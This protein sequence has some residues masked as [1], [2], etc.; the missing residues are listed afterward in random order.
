MSLRVPHANGAADDDDTMKIPR[1]VV[2]PRALGDR[3]LHGGS[4]RLIRRGL[5][6]AGSGG[7]L[8][9]AVY[10]G[11]ALR[12]RSINK[13]PLPD[14]VRPGLLPGRRHS[15]VNTDGTRLHLTDAGDGPP[16]LLAHGIAVTEAF[17]KH[18]QPALV[19]RGFRVITFDQRGHGSSTVGNDGFS[20]DALASDL[21]A[22]I[23]ELD[24]NDVV[25]VG[26]SMGG[27]ALQGFIADYPGITRDRV[28]HVVLCS[29]TPCND[30]TWAIFAKVPGVDRGISLTVP[31]SIVGPIVRTVM[32]GT[33]PRPPQAFID[34]ALDIAGVTDPA[35]IGRAAVALT[36]FD[37]RASLAGFTIPITVVCGR[38]DRVTQPRFSEMLIDKIPGAEAVWF[39]GAG[40]GLPWERINEFVEMIETRARPS[41]AQPG[42]REM[43]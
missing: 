19:G 43:R 29:T 14:G 27:I 28:R 10:G 34:D 36:E 15:V 30:A 13:I 35:V 18:T 23:D 40:H 2:S 31:R 32:F 42:Q 24:L 9:T 37:M 25:I 33:N 16:I 3:V 7:V 21:A 17:W 26:H 41:H 12:R 5:I 8:S 39:D 11:T 1:S 20:V 38:E 4:R 6:A 22:I